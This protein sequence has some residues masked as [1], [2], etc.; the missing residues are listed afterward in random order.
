MPR[1]TILHSDGDSV[2]IEETDDAAVLVVAG[3]KPLRTE[4]LFTVYELKE[5]G[6]LGR[7]VGSGEVA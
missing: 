1:Y 5:N 6:E 2:V 7:V 3:R 4:V